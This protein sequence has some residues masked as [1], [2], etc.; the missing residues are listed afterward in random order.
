MRYLLQIKIEVQHASPE[1]Y[2]LR[3]GCN[4]GASTFRL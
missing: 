3:L 1:T 2:M 4:S